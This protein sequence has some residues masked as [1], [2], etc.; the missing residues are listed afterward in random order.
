MSTS[1]GWEG[2]GGCSSFRL[3]MKRRV[4][5]W[6]CV[7]HWQCVLYLSASETLRVETLYKSTTFTFLHNIVDRDVGGTCE[8]S[9]IPW[10]THYHGIML[11]CTST[12]VCKVRLPF[13]SSLTA[14]RPSYVTAY[15]ACSGLLHC[16]LNK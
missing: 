13:D 8:Q 9:C 10:S 12:P 1:C 7:I 14:L 16:D 6:N 4:C 2:E 15:Q 3:R 5:R 11:E